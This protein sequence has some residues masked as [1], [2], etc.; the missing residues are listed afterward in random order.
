MKL[1]YRDFFTHSTK[2]DI[3]VHNDFS[4][5]QDEY[6]FDIAYLDDGPTLLINSK[7]QMFTEKLRSILKFGAVS[8]RY[9]DM[10]D[11][12]F[13]SV[14]TGINDEKLRECIRI[15][16]LNDSAMRENSSDEL[17]RRIHRVFENRKFRRNLETAKKNWLDVESSTVLSELEKFLLGLYA[18][19]K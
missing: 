19:Q 9:K 1:I 4:I 11:M 13:L 5:E 10:Y 15:L 17:L 8:T 14:L 6:C 12:Y 2:L 18:N 3:G 16:I 7:E